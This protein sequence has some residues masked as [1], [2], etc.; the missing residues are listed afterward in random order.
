[1]SDYID[2]YYQRMAAM[3]RNVKERALIQGQQ[4]FEEYLKDTPFL[5]S[6]YESPGSDFNGVVRENKQDMAKV[7]KKL[8]VSLDSTLTPGDILTFEDSSHWII[9]QKK[10]DINPAFLTF[11]IVKCNCE[12]QWVDDSGFT[13]RSLGYVVG[14]KDSQIK[15]NFRT[16]NNLITPQPNRWIEVLLPRTKI[17]SRNTKILIGDEGWY[18]IDFDKISVPGII[19]TTFGEEKLNQLTDD[20]ENNLADIDKLNTYEILIPN[21]RLEYSINQTILP[22]FYLI[23]N[24][25]KVEDTPVFTTT[26]VLRYS[27]GTFSATAD[28][29]GTIKIAYQGKLVEQSVLIT[30]T[31]AALPPFIIG[32]K[33]VKAARELVLEVVN[34]ESYTITLPNSL[35][36]LKKYEDNKVYL[37]ANTKGVLGKVLIDFSF[38]KSF[39]VEIVSLW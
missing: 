37:T 23:K 33:I 21:E 10:I 24:G 26:G 14:S 6:M 18:A 19:Y 8:L 28:G 20:I 29:F 36:A 16:W 39:E 1:M 17:L 27:N 31:P 35:L 9:Y 32:D 5:I 15:E 38:N 12:I 30:S 34:V 13:Q 25:K 4:A 3:G 7:T 2:I 11:Y 22:L